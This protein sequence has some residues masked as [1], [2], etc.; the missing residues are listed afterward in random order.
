M[1]RCARP[2][3]HVTHT[4]TQSEHS[5]HM[6]MCVSDVAELFVLTVCLGSF[7]RLFEPHPAHLR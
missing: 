1:Q 5:E 7:E 6:L 2:V 4:T 3:T